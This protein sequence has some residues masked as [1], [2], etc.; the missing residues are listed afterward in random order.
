MFSKIK[1]ALATVALA[2]LVGCAALPSD[3]GRSQATQYAA[4]RGRIVPQPADA[5]AFTRERLDGPLLPDVA[6]QIALVNSP[7]IRAETA[8]LGIA[9]AQVYDAG[10]LSN[11]GLSATRLSAGDPAA[12]NAQLT[13]GIAVSFVDLLLLPAN[14]R[15][16]AAE[17]EAA[18]LSMGS[19][20]LALAAE[21]ESGWYE[22]VGAEQLAQMR[23][24]VA[25]AARASAD[26]AQRFFDAG[27]I[28]RRELVMEQA[29]ASQAYLDALSARAEA[30]EARSAL[31]RRM[32]LPADRD[33]WTMDARLAEPLRNEDSLPDLYKL[34]ADSRLDVAAARARS[35]ALAGRYGLTRRTRFINSVEVGVER[36]K[37]YDGN[38][39]VGPTVALELPL[40]NFGA[41]RVAAARAALDSAEAELDGLLID[42]TNDV[43]RKQAA[44]AAAKSRAEAYRTALIPQREEVV[45]RMQQ[46]ANA[47]LI[48]VFEV[49][50]ARQQEYD[51]YAGYLEA[52]RDYWIART[53]LS[54]AA[55]RR[56]PSSD[57]H[58][59]ATLAPEALVAPIEET[60]HAH[61]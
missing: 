59:E 34:A 19:A 22:A 9:A 36:E 24:L 46:E 2:S 39:N 31:N 12:M 49:L 43:K 50:T 53:E 26:L 18:K 56:L 42:C 61:H 11:P 40:F 21:V 20:A 45:A 60:A 51:A 7:S 47:M 5:E 14:H 25:R 4:D 10:R 32:G 52:V 29:A 13:L 37:D 16:A 55:G 27:N 30:V 38:I 35:A 8:R 3:W 44:V 54:L 41:G 6:V 28:S 1:V 33:T 57:Q 17:F 15:Y 58:A 48:G 23:E